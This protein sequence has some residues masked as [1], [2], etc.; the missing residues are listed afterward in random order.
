MSENESHQMEKEIREQRKKEYLELG[1]ELS[2]AREGF[3]FPG[4]KREKYAKIKAEEREYPGMAAPVDELLNRLRAQGM[5]VVLGD[6]HPEN[7]I[8][9]VMP[10]NSRDIVN[11]SL[12]PK[13]LEISEG[14]D[15]RLAMLIAADEELG[16][17]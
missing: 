15:A 10:L 16:N 17:I 3:P 4:M 11:D 5:K 6:K 9:Y 1:R 12:F 2:E 13:H 7:A 14:M 8:V